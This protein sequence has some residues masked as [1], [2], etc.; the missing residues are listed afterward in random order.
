MIILVP[1]ATNWPSFMCIFFARRFCT[2]DSIQEWKTRI[3]VKQQQKIVK[4]IERHFLG[5]GS[6]LCASASHLLWPIGN[7]GT[8]ILDHNVIPL[9][10][11][12]K[13]NYDLSYFIFQEPVIYFPPLLAHEL[14]RGI[15]IFFVV[16]G[17]FNYH[18]YPKPTMNIQS[19]MLSAHT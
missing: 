10:I 8:C 5:K 16:L 1:T 9:Y 4:R 15:N 19:K 3:L 14:G 18:K 12:R 7:T 13:G 6:Q 17:L 2:R 11:C